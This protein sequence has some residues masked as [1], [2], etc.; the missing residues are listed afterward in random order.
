MT[1]PADA[2]G[3]AAGS[4]ADVPT[5]DSRAVDTPEVDPG[6]TDSATVARTDGVRPVE[7]GTTD[8]GTNAGQVG[9]ETADSAV[10]GDGTAPARKA[11][12][13][14]SA[15]RRVRA[16]DEQAPEPASVEKPRK[17]RRRAVPDAATTPDAAAPAATTTGE[18][19]TATGTAPVQATR[20]ATKK[21]ARRTTTSNVA[22]SDPATSD[23]ATSDTTDHTTTSDPA[24]SDAATSDTT[25][26]TTT[27]DPATSDTS[28]S[29]AAT[30]VVAVGGAGTSRT[31]TGAAGG[32]EFGASDSAD[33]V[34]AAGGVPLDVGTGRDISG[35]TPESDVRV[36]VA[37]MLDHP[38]F[39]PELL[40]LTAVEVL[41]PGAAQWVR[42]LRELYPG[43]GADGLA[44]LATRRFVRQAGVGGAGAALTGV[45]APVVELAAVLW[46]QANLVLHLAAAYGH[47]PAHPDRAAEL[48]TLTQVH[49]DVASAGSA[50]AAARAAQGPAE[51]PGLR[52]MEAAWRL[53]APLAAQAGGWLA[54]RLAS[55]LLPGMAALTAAAGDSAAAER[56]A[57][58]AVTRYR[59]QRLTRAG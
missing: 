14:T 43:A 35:R 2:G 57:A 48:L 26:H 33:V 38:G 17:A 10:A 20:K 30:D 40:A 34:S 21:A 5:T 16:S 47:D 56:L 7:T 45:F 39:A 13:A 58:R 6:S 46:S 8:T 15:R 53:A 55:R 22:T 42:R 50:V 29:T 9:G 11:A 25:D 52:A 18:A 54:L 36:H 31:A 37:R 23:A 41:G 19:A 4:G 12:K 49:P 59:P 51:E 27:S 24:T 44:R 28:T 3:G 1:G 32:S